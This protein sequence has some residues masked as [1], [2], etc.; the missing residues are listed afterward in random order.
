MADLFDGISDWLLEQ[1]LQ[2][3]DLRGVICEL[4]QRLIDGGV[5]VNRINIGRSVLHPVFGLMNLRWEAESN[6]AIVEEIPRSEIDWDGLVGQPFFELTRGAEDRIVADL[7]DPEQVARYALFGELA[8]RGMT[9]Y[10]AFGRVFGRRTTFLERFAEDFRG[11]SV[12]FTTKRFSGFT[13]AD[14]EGLERLMTPLC[15]CLLVA[16]EHFLSDEL[17]QAYPGRITG[18]QVLTGQSARGDGQVIDCA[19]LY[20]DMRDSVGLSQRMEA[21]DYLATLNAYYD[22]TA[23]AVLDHGGEVLKF[24]GDGIL[25]IF[26]IEDG[27]RPARNMCAAALSAARDGF[28]RAETANAARREAGAPLFAFGTALHLGQVIYGN[29]GTAKRLDFT[30]TGSAVNLVSRCEALTRTL[31]VPLIATADFAALIDEPGRDL[32]R[33]DVRGLDAP[34]ALV[35][36]PL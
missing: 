8:A 24:I 6:Q 33:H 20:S 12:S 5:P 36:Y 1:A 13:E 23:Q 18:G 35:S 19:L 2:T 10:V 7:R 28:V 32:D 29:V 14:H 11:A 25:A 26:P 27:K 4:G 34:A 31:N 16:T 17:M 30:A 15:L 3:S 22:C 21:P 9:G